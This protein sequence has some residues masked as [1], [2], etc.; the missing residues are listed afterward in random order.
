[1]TDLATMSPSEIDTQLADL[2]RAAS[3]AGQDIKVAYER[4]HQTLGERRV[5]TYGKLGGW[6]TTDERALALA[7]DR[8]AAGERPAVMWAGG[9][10][11]ADMIA[12]VEQAE[13][14]MA[15]IQA[16][17]E[18][19]NAEFQRRPWS[20]FFTVPA[21]HIHSS[22]NCS[23]CNRGR[24]A[25]QFGWNPELSGLSEADAVAAKGPQLCTVCFPSAPVEWTVGE[26]KP[27]CE[28]SAKAPVADTVTRYGMRAYG[29]CTGC[30]QQHLLTQ[31]GVIR[32]H[33]PAK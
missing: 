1:M 30:R 4:L 15:E 28:G 5:R 3:V 22:M 8:A 7:K 26:A 2:Y 11:Y 6:P 13:A 21:G 18:P 32:K 24:Y 25:T 19:F 31:W 23:T 27:S 29:T 12:K 14:K 33:A 20:R 10:G 17:A 16:A 9:Y